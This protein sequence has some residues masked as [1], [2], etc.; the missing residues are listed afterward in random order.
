MTT[1]TLVRTNGHHNPAPLTQRTAFDSAQTALLSR[2]IAK[3]STPDELALFVAVCNRTGLDPF[4]RQIFA[5]KRWDNRER[6][7]VMSIQVSIDGFRLIAERS[8]HYAGQLGPMWCGP[9]G[10]DWREVWLEDVPP[11]AAKVAVLRRDFDEP[12]W[13]VATFA[14]Y[15]QRNKEG[16]L[17]GLW[18]KMP[19][20]MLGKAAEALALRRAFPAELSGLYAPEEMD[21]AVTVE[22]VQPE[23]QPA[24][25]PAQQALTAATQHEADDVIDA[26]PSG[27]DAA[28]DAHWTPQIAEQTTT[29]GTWALVETIL[30]A[31]TNG[32]RRFAAIK[33]AVA[34]FLDLA[35]MTEVVDMLA[36]VEEEWPAS[37]PCRTWIVEALR[38]AAREG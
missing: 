17:S 30:T 26:E 32:Q 22:A 29:V 11:A 24:H 8:G 35:K 23:P 28:E 25:Q 31:E 16:G 10:V 38:A 34:H 9:D 33:L 7:E 4:A 14:Q 2:T 5:V 6:R 12:L 19:S 1:N 3:G 37:T 18:G 27:G 15:A 36:V 13:A 21:Q 20:L